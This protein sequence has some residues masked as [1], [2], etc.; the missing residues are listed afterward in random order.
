M[1]PILM[2]QLMM[3]QGGDSASSDISEPTIS[4]ERDEDNLDDDVEDDAAAEGSDDALISWIR[5]MDERMNQTEEILQ[6]MYPE[7]LRLA[8]EL[9]DIKNEQIIQKMYEK[10]SKSGEPSQ[11][12][13]AKPFFG[14]FG[15]SK[16]RN[17]PKKT[18]SWKYS[19]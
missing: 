13:K 18:L 4:I 10:K 9:Q 16:R 7:I 2:Q 11:P 17:R 12:K 19:N 1:D 5:R 15:G 14:L 3:K 6:Q 8:G